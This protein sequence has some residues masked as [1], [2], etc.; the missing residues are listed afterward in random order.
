MTERGTVYL[1]GRVT[2]READ[3]ATQIARGISGVQQV[4][5]IFE[6]LTEAELATRSRS[7]PATPA[8]A[9]SAP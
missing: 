7:R 4:V 6:I 1:M 5:R 2:K 9:A 8:G 3:R